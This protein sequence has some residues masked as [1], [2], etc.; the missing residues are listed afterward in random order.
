MLIVITNRHLCQ[1]DFLL[2]IEEVC[3][4]QPSRIILR[5]KDLSG[6]KYLKLATKCQEICS[7]YGVQ[8][9]I[10]SFIT[11]AQ[12]LGIPSIHLPYDVFMKF[13]K[14]LPY[15]SEIGVSIHSPEEAFKLRN[16]N[17]TYLIAGHIFDTDCKK[18][19][20]PR[21]LAYLKSVCDVAQQPVFA[22]G[23]IKPEYLK[24]VYHQGAS[25]VCVMSEVM[26]S[27]NVMATVKKFYK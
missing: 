20:P 14:E 16:T 12:N 11:I 4:A 6:S 9:V 23:G 13:H 18:D 1:P 26:Q 22:I 10:N 19:V 3:K 7:Y 21:G 2:K 27:N 5:E 25:G 15:F 17:C 8:L 24:D